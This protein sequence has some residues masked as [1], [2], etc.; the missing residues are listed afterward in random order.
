MR[1]LRRCSARLTSVCRRCKAAS[2]FFSGLLE[3]H[4]L[5][6]RAEE[7]LTHIGQLAES[8]REYQEFASS[9]AAAGP[10]ADPA[11]DDAFRSLLWTWF[12]RKLVI[13]EDSHTSG[14]RII[15]MI[16]QQTP[17]GLHNRIMGMQNIKGT[18][19]DFVYRWQA[20]EACF[21]ACQDLKSRDGAIA[22]S[23][24]RALSA[25]QE[26]GVL[27]EEYVRATVAE[28]RHSPNAQS[29]LFQ[30]ELTVILSNLVSAMQ[31]VHAEMRMS[32]G[33]GGGVLSGLLEHVEAFLDA[34][35]A[36]KRRKQANQIYRDLAAERISHERAA[37]ELQ[38]LT[39]RQKGG[40]LQR[41]LGGI[42]YPLRVRKRTAET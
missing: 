16:M 5:G 13:V 34:G 38:I 6:N 2:R 27:C 25:F 37:L 17:P 24:L 20:W 22:E 9:L 19:L 15:Q 14:N 8:C 41:S 29:E 35:D 31:Q 11:L 12:E 23:G 1:C 32:G 28:V 10:S 42:L 36:V 21:R 33:G 30:G 39:K 3:K 7:V 18:G 40:W 4:E 26:Y